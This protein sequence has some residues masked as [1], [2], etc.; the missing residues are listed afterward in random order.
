MKLGGN[1]AEFFYALIRRLL[2][3]NRYALR[4]H[5]WRF[6]WIL[7]KLK[8]NIQI[9]L[10]WREALGFRLVLRGSDFWGFQ[11]LA[12][13][14]PPKL[15]ANANFNQ[16]ST[17]KARVMGWN[18]FTDGCFFTEKVAGV[19]AHCCYGLNYC[20]RNFLKVLKK[21]K[22]ELWILKCLPKAELQN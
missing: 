8:T 15:S 1:Y 12:E 22:H 20:M 7:F 19:Y 13:V 3:Q 18:A 9:S 6:K 14:Q 4:V 21:C 17:S 2:F 5:L 10:R 11:L 16:H